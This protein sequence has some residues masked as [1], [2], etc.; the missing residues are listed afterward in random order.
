MLP[1]VTGDNDGHR[2]ISG[3]LELNAVNE[4]S[5]SPSASTILNHPNIKVSFIYLLLILVMHFTLF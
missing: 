5:I 1:P 3:V 4:V 2:K